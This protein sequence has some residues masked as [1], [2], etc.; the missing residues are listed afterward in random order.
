MNELNELNSLNRFYDWLHSICIITF[1][2]EL[3][4]SFELIYPNDN[5][6]TSIDKLNISYLSFPDSN[7]NFIGNLKYHFRIKLNNS[8]SSSLNDNSYLFGYVYFRQIKDNKLKRGYFQKSLV[9][10]SKYPYLILFKYILDLIAPEYFI[11]E[12]KQ[13]IESICYDINRWP[14]PI[15][16]NQLLTLPIM[17]YVIQV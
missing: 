3:G 15:I 16:N 9:L 11:N 10:L 12:N 17:G 6:L 13:I 7:S 5:K 2:I 4:Q 8:S 14:L 1:D